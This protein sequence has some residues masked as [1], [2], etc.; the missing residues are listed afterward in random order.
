MQRELMT[1]AMQIWRRAGAMATSCIPFPSLQYCYPRN[2]CISLM[3][4]AKGGQRGVLQIRKGRQYLPNQRNTAGVLAGPLPL[5]SRRSAS[6]YQGCPDMSEFF[7]AT[8]DHRPGPRF[9]SQ[10]SQGMAAASCA[11]RTS[12]GWMV[13]RQLLA[14]SSLCCMAGA[15]MFGSALAPRPFAGTA[16]RRFEPCRS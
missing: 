16:R 3:H 14:V 12:S 4:Q 10:V 6:G 9:K 2:A 5:L 15:S 8:L 7:G 1:N 13:T 11:R